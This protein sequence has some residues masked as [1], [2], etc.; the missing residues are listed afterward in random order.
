[1]TGGSRGRDLSSRYLVQESHVRIVQNPYVGNVVTQHGDSSRSH[2]ECP[3]GVAIAIESGGVK[4]RG[5]HHPRAEYLH[6]AG[7][8]AAWAANAMTQLALHIHLRRRFRER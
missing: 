5:M 2:A 8:L 7:S 3:S 1:M 6:P 4:H